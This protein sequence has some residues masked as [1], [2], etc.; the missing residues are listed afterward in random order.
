MG[1]ASWK[2]PES[3]PT[4]V[5]RVVGS[6][7]DG[8]ASS[9][10]GEVFAFIAA[11]DNLSPLESFAIEDGALLEQPYRGVALFDRLNE[12]R[13]QGQLATLRLSLERMRP[14]QVSPEWFKMAAQAGV[15]DVSFEVGTRRINEVFGITRDLCN[16]AKLS[17][18]APHVPL[19]L[20]G[21]QIDLA[22]GAARAVVL[23]KNELPWQP[24][25]GELSPELRQQL[26]EPLAHAVEHGTTD[27]ATLGDL[28]LGPW[29]Q[30]LPPSNRRALF[31]I[32]VVAN[33]QGQVEGTL[34][35]KDAAL[36]NLAPALKPAF[37][38]WLEART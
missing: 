38:A 34:A 18:I 25:P 29:F 20:A 3:G 14:R 13:R 4:R 12:V 1:E 10:A 23:L 9:S 28:I 31:P 19:R 35:G 30:F 5:L 37:T 24:E 33:P 17:G 21:P 6:S 22:E 26:P 7:P 16:V 11:Q 36:A 15:S 2:L 32:W 27:F 8:T